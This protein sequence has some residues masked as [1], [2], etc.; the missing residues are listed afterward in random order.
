MHLLYAV[1]SSWRNLYA[2]V[3][4]SRKLHVSNG[5]PI[6]K[7][8]NILNTVLFVL[9]ILLTKNMLPLCTEPGLP[10]TINRINKTS[11]NWHITAVDLSK[12]V[13]FLLHY[14]NRKFKSLLIRN[15]LHKG[16]ANTGVVYQYECNQ[17]EAGSTKYIGYTT[18]SLTKYA[19]I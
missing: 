8:Q 2:E 9:K 7:H 10:S 15:K 4:R 6:R 11:K 16:D 17:V 3:S 5:F 14:Q 18:C 19:F 13:H 12:G 1:S